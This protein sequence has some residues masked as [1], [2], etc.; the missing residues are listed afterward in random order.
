M[1][2]EL[3]HVLGHCQFW[4]FDQLELHVRCSSS[5]EVWVNDK[6]WTEFLIF[7]WNWNLGDLLGGIVY[8]GFSEYCVVNWQTGILGYMD[9]RMLESKW[10][11]LLVRGECLIQHIQHRDR[12]MGLYGKLRLLSNGLIMDCAY[13]DAPQSVLICITAVVGGLCFSRVMGGLDISGN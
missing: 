8:V 13:V 7:C 4:R 6:D 1:E 5:R 11:R 2:V 9:T 10:R 12:L 3:D